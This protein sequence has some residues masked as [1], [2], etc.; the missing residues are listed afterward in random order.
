MNF[1]VVSNRCRGRQRSPKVGFDG[2]CEESFRREG[3]AG[4]AG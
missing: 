1:D 3:Y 2:W 4:G